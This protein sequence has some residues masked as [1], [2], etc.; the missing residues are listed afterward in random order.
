MHNKYLFSSY[1]VLSVLIIILVLTS[2]NRTGSERE[3]EPERS[4]EPGVIVDVESDR[5]RKAVADF[6]MSL[7]ASQTDQLRFA[8]NKMNEVVQAYP[9]E[10]SAWANLAV[11]ALRQGNVELAVDRINSALELN[12]NHAD[13]LFLAGII[14]SRRGNISAAVEY[15]KNGKEIAP[16]NPKILFALVQE[17]ERED[18]QANRDE[19]AEILNTLYKHHPNNQAVLT[20]L[21]RTGVKNRNEKMIRDGLENLKAQQDQS[22]DAADR[23]YELDRMLGENNYSEIAAEIPF[24]RN[25]LASDPRFQYDLNQ[26]QLPESGTG[27]LITY[28]INLPKPEMRVAEPDLE[29]I[30]T[31]M[32][33]DLPGVAAA[34]VKGVSLLEESPPFPVAI[35]NGEMVIDREV[36]FPFPG[37]TERRLPVAAVSEIDYN[38]NFRNDLALAGNGGFR[39]YRMNEDKTYSD[40]TGEIGISSRT[41]NGEYYGLWVFDIEMDGDL[42]ILLAPESGEAFVLRNNGDAAFTETTPFSGANRIRKFAWADL[43]G[44]GTPEAIML[45]EEGVITIYKNLRGGQF[46]AGTVLQDNSASFVVADI[47]ADGQFN[48][49]TVAS[50]GIVTKHSY[51]MKT[52]E[53]ENELLADDWNTSSTP[54]E[55]N[56]FVADI[57][58]NGSVDL[59]LSTS[60]ETVI[61]LGDKDRNMVR[62]PHDVPGGIVDVFDVD[63]NERLD[64]LGITSGLEP[65]HLKN[66]GTRNYFARSIRARASGELGDQRINSY[67]IG[68]EME[69]R[70]GLLYQKQLITSPIVHFGLGEYEEVQMLRIIWPNGSVQAEFAELGMGATIFNEQI[71]K[72]SCPWLFTN[73]GTKVRFITDILWRSPL[74]LRINEQETAGVIQTFDRV[75]IP[76]DKLNAVNGIYDLRITAELWETHFFDYVNLIAVDHPV[77][78]QIFVDERFVFPPPD[79]STRLVSEPVPVAK[80]TDASGNDHTDTVSKADEQ[81]ISPFEK[82][83]YQGLVKE[84]S[85]EIELAE[86]DTGEPGWLILSGWLRPTDS[87]LNLALS[88]GSREPPGGIRVEVSGSDGNWE[89]LHENFGIP[90]GKLKSILIDLEDV[91]NESGDKKIR[92]TTTSEIYWD[93]ILQARK[94]DESN[95][96][97]TSLDAVHMELKYRG[98]SEWNRADKVSPKLPDYE[99]ISSASQ[100]WRDLEGFHT[101]FGDVSELLSGIDDRYVIMNAGDEIILHFKAPDAPAEGMKRSFVFVSDGWVKDGDYNT[102]ASGTVLPLPFHGQSDYEYKRISRL[103]DDPVYQKHAKDWSEYHTRYVTSN[104]F[105]SALSFPAE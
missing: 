51:S 88:Q 60:D 89:A 24:L 2:C 70:S 90:A 32:P 38:Y 37:S 44:D 25:E 82:T 91:F 53:W 6:Y 62:Y 104:E 35:T 10:S 71:L 23:L 55:V 33:L 42:D 79:L 27:F 66:E 74:G 15:L 63:G 30:L 73:D 4:S 14:H 58:N 101:R 43:D 47:D 22:V 39:L 49:I 59:I 87:S 75:R 17:L 36:R 13:L 29:L 31:Q 96:S 8:F 97:E 68:G 19:I 61:W 84:H 18:D 98:Y 3:S 83:A 28:F 48:I 93:T 92:L 56:F 40:I 102:E 54:G 72:G 81:Y 50:N 103:S 99:N 7:G 12:P 77:G 9:Q 100:R 11:Y 21:L 76:G 65:F 86:M 26:V 57:D 78:T 85:I 20:E 67:G 80:V 52:S 95:L 64:L 16:R 105:R 94:V 46:D 41:V 34:W 5:Y 69:I 45:S 1:A